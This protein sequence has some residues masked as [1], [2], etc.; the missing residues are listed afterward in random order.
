MMLH[1]VKLFLGTN[2]KIIDFFPDQVYAE[3]A[4]LAITDGSPSADDFKRLDNFLTSWTERVLRNKGELSDPE[5]VHEVCKLAAI[6]LLLL[7]PFVSLDD[8]YEEYFDRWRLLQDF[9]LLREIS[10]TNEYL[11][12]VESDKSG[13]KQNVL[14]SIS[15]HLCD[16]GISVQELLAKFPKYSIH[17]MAHILYFM[18][19]RR[20]VNIK[21]HDGDYWVKERKEEEKEE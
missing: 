6:S 21:K 1:P 11:D 17:D 10:T 13:L 19:V 2:H 8:V 20:E 4:R 14:E 3:L 18:E 9:L 7:I 15:S 12:F 5:G 16:S